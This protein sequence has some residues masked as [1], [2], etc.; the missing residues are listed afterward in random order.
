MT[1]DRTRKIE[2]LTQAPGT[3]DRSGGREVL[4]VALM[5][6]ILVAVLL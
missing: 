1:V 4:A 6:V 5:A 3:V 2:G